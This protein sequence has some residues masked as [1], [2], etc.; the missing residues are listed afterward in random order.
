MANHSCAGCTEEARETPAL[1]IISIQPESQALWKSGLCQSLD[2][3]GHVSLLEKLLCQIAVCDHYLD[4]AEKCNLPCPR[5]CWC[6]ATS[7][8]ALLE[9]NYKFLLL[10]ISQVSFSF[11]NQKF[12]IMLFV[13]NHWYRKKLL[14]RTSPWMLI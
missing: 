13:Y 7:L 12:L 11:F 5:R 8:P 9:S 2:C 6:E 3:N 4:L 1:Q 10:A 14:T